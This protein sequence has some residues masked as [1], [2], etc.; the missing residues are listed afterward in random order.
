MAQDSSLNASCYSLILFPSLFPSPFKL[1]KIVD[2][3]VMIKML[4]KDTPTLMGNK[5]K[6]N[7]FKVTSLSLSLYLYHALNVYTFSSL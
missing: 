3:N 2:G 4:V 1:S 6:Q 7:Y 5:L